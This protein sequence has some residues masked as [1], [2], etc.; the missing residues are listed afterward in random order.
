MRAFFVAALMAALIDVLV[1]QEARTGFEACL[2][3]YPCDPP[4]KVF[5]GRIAQFRA[6]AP[7]T[8]WD[9]VWSLVE[10]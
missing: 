3:I 7:C 6:T 1:V 9:G 8:S 2:A 4:S 10:K 5:L